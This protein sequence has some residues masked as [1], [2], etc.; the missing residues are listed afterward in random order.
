MDKELAEA[1]DE[2][3]AAFEYPHMYTQKELIDIAYQARKTLRK[4]HDAE[5]ER[6][7]QSHGTKAYFERCPSDYSTDF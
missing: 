4:Y 2:L 3:L 6:K 5:R 7:E 1:L